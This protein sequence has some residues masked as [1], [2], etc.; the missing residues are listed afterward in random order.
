MGLTGLLDIKPSTIDIDGKTY[1]LE[2]G[3]INNTFL[4]WDDHAIFSIGMDLDFGG[5]RQGF[6]HAV[7]QRGEY[8]GGYIHEILGIVG[9]RCWEDLKNDKVYA[10]RNS[11][12]DLIRGLMDFN[13][14]RYIIFDDMF[15]TMVAKT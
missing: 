4:G 14:T 10:L 2:L 15:A 1:I 6:T 7:G 12:N 8:L 5:T 11:R 13:Q 3:V 9:E